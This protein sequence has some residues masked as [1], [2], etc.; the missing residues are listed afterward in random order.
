MSYPKDLDEYTRLELKEELARREQALLI[1]ICDYCGQS[2]LMKPCRFPERHAV[3]RSHAEWLGHR[4]CG[5]TGCAKP[6]THIIQGSLL[7]HSC[8]EHVE[9]I[10][11]LVANE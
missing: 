7:Y 5:K 1:G 6:G 9:E 8:D 4:L 11:T 10:Q 3:A 2:G